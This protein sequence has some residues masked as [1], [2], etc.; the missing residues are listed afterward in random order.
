MGKS[1]FGKL[2]AYTKG[3]RGL[4]VAAMASTV[5]ATL[6][7]LLDP[8]VV[9]AVLDYLVDPAGKAMPAW[10]PGD[11]RLWAAAGAI[12]ALNLVAGLF[13]YL[14][15]YLSALAS[16]GAAERLRARLYA[17]LLALPAAYHSKAR[18]GDLVQRSTSDVDTVRKFLA[19]QLEELSRSFCMFAIAAAIMFAI[20]WRMAL[21]ALCLVPLVFAF[22]VSF[23]RK[24]QEVFARCDEAEAKM[25]SVLQENLAGIRVVRAFDRARHEEARFDARNAAYTAT[26]VRLIDLFGWYWSISSFL[27]MAQTGIVLATGGCLAALGIISPGTMILFFAYTGRLLWPVRQLGRV[28]TELGKALV[29]T[30]R[31]QEILE[32]EGESG[33]D[34]LPGGRGLLELR[35]VSLEYEA[36]KKVLSGIDLRIEPGE[37]LAILG[38]TGSGKSSLVHL[39]QRL[40]DPTEG[41]VLLDGVDLRGLTLEALRKKVA[42]VLQEPML[43]SRSLL[44]NIRLARPGAAMEA[45][46]LAVRESSLDAVVAKFERGYETAVGEEGV[47]LSGG[48]RQRVA[49]ARA[50]LLE[51][52]VLVLDDS[53]S[54]V[55]AETD[56]RIREAL[57]ARR[58]RRTTIVIAHRISTLAGADRILVLEG[59]R[60]AQEGSHAELILAEGL[61]R[62]VWEIQNEGCE[63]DS[64]GILAPSGGTR[65]D[66]EDPGDRG[67]LLAV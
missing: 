1:K 30:G 60:I 67:D 5:A 25:T 24:I 43:F 18:A 10:I 62:K 58:G 63:A 52:E 49:I 14:R 45:V 33:G 26:T 61:Y 48:Q 51:S 3:G 21:V 32:A 8:L 22:T 56:A 39:F 12:V 34:L 4:F 66:G 59:G 37:T 28:L 2:L 27:C 64:A 23:F 47:T 41:E 16:E 9:R 50:L 38:R 31:I 53:L 36:G 35:G 55:D 6:F 54:A 44:D 42:I 46:E 20:D 40:F 19:T 29:S 13:L 57:E 7:S 17:K 15:G 11:L 65:A